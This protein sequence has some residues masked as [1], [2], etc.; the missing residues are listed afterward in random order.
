MTPAGSQPAEYTPLFDWGPPR[1]PRVSLFTF[2]AASLVLHALCFYLFQIVY[3]IT[4]AL[5]PPP[6]RVQLINPA[7]E[8]G[9]VL[10]RWIEAEDPALSSTTQR[11]EQAQATLPSA[12]A[13]IPSYL[14]RQPA[15]KQLPPHRPDLRIP[16]AHPPGPVALPRAS[17]PAPAGTTASTVDFAHA[18]ILGPAQVPALQFTAFRGEPPTAAQFRLG[19]DARG[20]VRHCFLEQ[21]SGDPALDEQARR[22]LLQSR[23]P[24][25][26]LPQSAIQNLLFWTTA[27]LA[28]GND[29]TA[30]VA[31]PAESPAP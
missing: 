20:V 25:I 31:A 10:L 18:D 21:P 5:L 16:S 30:P 13:H 22:I 4:V 29:L 3:P 17:S 9:R 2:L 6:A 26:R 27:A 15:L 23:F 8:Q 14:R 7:S 1:R 19:I 24:K 28:W 11:P 12:P